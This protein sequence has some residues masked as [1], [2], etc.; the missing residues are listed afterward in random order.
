[1]P[2]CA[3][4]RRSLVQGSHHVYAGLLPQPLTVRRRGYLTGPI[5]LTRIISTDPTGGRT[6]SVDFHL[7]LNSTGFL[8]EQCSF[9]SVPETDGL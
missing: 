5:A 9:P 4:L 3:S 2:V 7:A 6:R 1:M 8:Q